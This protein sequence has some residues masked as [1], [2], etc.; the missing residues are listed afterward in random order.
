[1]IKSLRMAEFIEKM[2]NANPEQKS[3]LRK[4][5][6]AKLQTKVISKTQQG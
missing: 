4:K 2:K 3:I 1:M 5:M 6:I